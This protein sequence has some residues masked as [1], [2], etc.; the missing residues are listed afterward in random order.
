[1]NA[2]RFGICTQLNPMVQPKYAEIWQATKRDR[3]DEY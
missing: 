2:P 1:M 3:D